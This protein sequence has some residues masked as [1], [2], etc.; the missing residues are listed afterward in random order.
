MDEQHR[1]LWVICVLLVSATCAVHYVAPEDCRWEPLG[2]VRSSDVSLTCNLRT[3]NGVFDNTNF[4]VIQSAHTISLTVKCQDILFESSLLNNAVAHL[5]ELKNLDIEFCKLREIP[6]L[7]FTG[8]S[9]VVNLTLRTYNSRWGEFPLKVF[10]DSFSHLGSLKR[11]DLSVNNIDVLPPKVFCGLPHLEY[12]NLT[13]N[14]FDEVSD[15]A[16]HQTHATC[17]TVVQELDVSHNRIKVLPNRGFSRSFKLKILSLKFNQ[18][19]R[20]EDNALE[21]LNQLHTLE[22]SHNQLVALPP[23]FFQHTDQLSELHLQNNSISVI[24]PRLF[25]G[26]QKLVTLDLSY[27]R[28]SSQW[29]NSDTFADLIRLVVFDLSHNQITEIGTATFRSQY[30]LQVLRLQYNKIVN[31]AEN[32]FASLYNLHTLILSHNRITQIEY[33]TLNGLFVLSV[34]SFDHNNINA[35]HPDS[36]RNCTSLM[37]LSLGNNHLFS[38]PLSLQSLRQLRSLELGDN[39]ISDIHNASYQG[40][41]QLYSLRLMGNEI[42]N[43]TNGVFQNLP[44]LRILD[45]S[46]NKIQALEQGTLDDVPDLHALRL[47]S[48]L[49]TDINGLF[50]NLHDLLM[51]NVSANKIG[52]F[53]YA[54]IPIGLQWLDIHENEIEDLGNYFQLESVLKLRTLDASSNAIHQLESSSL[55]HGI[56]IVYLAKNKIYSI[57]PF[58]FLGKANLT[59]VDLRENQLKT[60]EMN[61]FRLSAVISR[62]PL[63]EFSVS[64]NPFICDCNMEWLQRLKSLGESR[65]YPDMVDVDK[66]VCQLSTRLPASVPLI[67]A[68][69]SQFL[70]QYRS[71]CFALCHCCDFDACD[72][73]MVCPE[74]CTCYYDQSWS[75]NI[76]DCSSL[77]LSVV[78][79]KIPMDVTELY[80]D[81]ND[82]PSLYSHTFIGR[83]NMKILFLNNSNIRMISNRTFNGLRALKELNL[84]HNKI[85]T[86]HGFEFDRLTLLVKLD[87]SYN[88]LKAISNT[89]FTALRFL[90]VLHLE[91]NSLVEFPVFDPNIQLRALRLAHNPWSCECEFLETFSQWFQEGVDFVEDIAEVQCVFNESLTVQLLDFNT[92]SCNNI[93]ASTSFIRKNRVQD[94][95]YIAI[96]AASLLV[97]LLI[98]L[99]LVL[100]FRKR[101]SL[102]CY[103][104]Y[105]IRLF[106]R[107]NETEK[108]QLFDA[109]VSYSKKDETFVTQILTPELEYGNPTYRLCLH[110]RD[111]P[112]GG[113]M[114]DAITEAMESS[115]RT[116]VILSENFLKSEWCRYEFKA[117]HHEVLR[118]NKHRLIVVFLGKVIQ[119]DLDPEIRSWIKNNTFLR[120]G[121]K[122]FWEKLR[123][124]MPDI[125]QRTSERRRQDHTSVAVHI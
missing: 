89:T 83:K 4:S 123:Y 15:L 69:S 20:A 3:L 71:H 53:D 39:R 87:L 122:L 23:S 11:L 66:I 64:G 22:L 55:P 90:E 46:R 2:G 111:L 109:F 34:L 32:T 17:D 113:Y 117:A 45:L 35:I 47:D 33:L 98:L 100:V 95:L 10:P 21:G 38:V 13:A 77:H 48:N 120:W 97:I 68:N 115:R 16:L 28:I 63:P 44:S 5:S 74:N 76:V 61:S 42:G 14:L 52:W 104:K 49:L 43:L 94:I 36:F 56:E 78:P 29:I 18:I 92:T 41:N 96:T 105:G 51:L 59:R 19:G 7:A 57:K 27:N 124:A 112:V 54:L 106:H 9:K 65:Q 79:P 102:W 81:G 60:L 30:S 99:A 1:L 118:S 86:L 25:S 72:C 80:L 82:F 108:E 67:K 110:Y 75:T 84:Q 37:E 116:I 6:T 31:I 50:S 88:S 12:V 103:T 119:R 101:M 24:P 125:R 40:L 8:L 93:T 121:E 26:L 107:C 114:S 91:H 58:T 85:G 73:E 70:C 62:K